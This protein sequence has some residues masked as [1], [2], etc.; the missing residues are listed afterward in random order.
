MCLALSVLLLA[1]CGNVSAADPLERIRQQGKLR[2]AL[3]PTYPPFEELVNGQVQGLDVDIAMDLGKRIGVPVVFVQQP[4]DKIYQALDNRQADLIISALYPE[5]SALTNYAFS[6]PYF[7]AG[8]LIVVP[9]NSP[10]RTKSQLAGLRIAVINNSEGLLEI[11]RWQYMLNPPPQLIT[12]DK[13]DDA[14]NALLYGEVDA[15]VAHAI[16]AHRA[17]LLHAELRLLDESVTDEMYVMA[18]RREDEAFI[19]AVSEYLSQ[20]QSDGTL[21]AIFARWLTR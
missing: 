12:Y 20:M 1:A 4:Y 8:Q 2:I 7:N 11:S 15:L 6:Q 18:A 5:G 16:V 14:I 21:D 9:T 17:R 3:D 19:K 10:V 13:P